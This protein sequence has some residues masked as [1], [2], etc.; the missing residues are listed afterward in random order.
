MTPTAPTPSRGRPGLRPRPAVVG[1]LIVPALA[2]AATWPWIVDFLTPVEVG[3]GTRVRLTELAVV[4]AALWGAAACLLGALARRWRPEASAWWTV[5]AGAIVWAMGALAG[6]LGGLAPTA[7]PSHGGAAD[8]LQVAGF[9]LML[10]GSLLVPT[11]GPM[12]LLRRIDLTLV[13][14][15]VLI[16][17]WSMAQRLSVADAPEALLH[18]GSLVLGAAGVLAGAALVIRSLPQHQPEL[19][20]LVAALMA[21][22]IAYML[23]ADRGPTSAYTYRSLAADLCWMVMGL[24]LVVAGRRLREPRDEHATTRRVTDRVYSWLPA[25][26][27]IVG[28]AT[29]AIHQRDVGAL[30]PALTVLGTALVVLSAT[31]GALMHER[32]KMLLDQLRFTAA[33]MA[34]AGRT[35]ELTGLGNRLGL[36]IRLGEALERQ[37]PHGVSV[38][39]IDIDN[40]KDVNDTLGHEAGDQLLHVLAD[41]L[42]GVLGHD[43][44]RIGGDEFVA[45]REDL[46]PRSAEAIAAAIVAALGP[47]VPLGPHRVPSGASVGLARS[48][49]RADGNRR[50]D[51]PQLLLRRADLALYRAKELGRGQWASYEPWLQE[52][53][54][55]RLALQQGLRSAITAG[56]LDV[57]YQPIVDLHTGSTVGAEALVR[58]VS[59]TFGILLPLEFLPLA[60]E[61]DLMPALGEHVLSAV[62]DRLATSEVPGWVSVNLSAAELLHP[63]LVER[64][65]RHLRLGG[66]APQRLR[67]EVT[68]AVVLDPAVR[69]VLGQL[70]AMG[71]RTCIED[72]GT[73]PTSLRYLSG[74]SDLTLK[75]DRSFLGGLGR[76]HDERV[77]LA[78]V[79]DLA[80]DLAL[81]VGVEAV[82]TERQAEELRRLGVEEAQG[83]LLGE[84]VAWSRLMDR[85]ADPSVPRG[86]PG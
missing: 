8:V 51:E 28:L 26:A 32:N 82:T 70:A 78:A 46:D 7:G 57:V 34:R 31:R 50:R 74:L 41:R 27:T 6:P 75:M 61:A 55:R 17:L 66:V 67:V 83:W 79:T 33:Q 73:G 54:D 80:H 16:V 11:R 59:P 39:F 10:I 23:A 71:V 35:D 36:E 47:P 9:A 86:A 29:A 4:G 81:R 30:V 49:I 13:L 65:A 5:G 72:F 69:G 42:M 68:E 58:W 21:G 18:S 19:R 43:V 76:S 22:G 15:A 1:A 44:F 24:S 2:L 38:F 25:T 63:E 62:V 77:V 64:V 12:D 48:E 84:P 14:T 60:E 85:L 20:G 53:A 37:S 52:R 3:D 45:V 56:Q 40:F